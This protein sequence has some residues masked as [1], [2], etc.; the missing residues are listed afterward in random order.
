MPG[1]CPK[2]RFLLLG[3]CFC[4]L[5]SPVK[6]KNIALFCSSLPAESSSVWKAAGIGVAHS[7]DPFNIPDFTLSE[8][9]DLIRSAGG[10]HY[11]P[12]IPLNEAVPGISPENMTRLKKAAS[13]PAILDA[14]IDELSRQGKWS[15]LDGLVD[16]FT[17][18]GIKL[19]LVAGCGY[20]KEAPLYR[21]ADGSMESISPDRL[22]RD[23]YLAAVKW[24]AGAAVRRYGGRVEFW[25]V[26][27][28]INIASFVARFGWRIK[29]DSWADKAYCKRLISALAAI[30]HSEGVKLKKNLKTT[31]NFATTT[32]LYT[33]NIPMDLAAFSAPGDLDI[34]GLDFYGNYLLGWP[35]SADASVRQLKETVRAAGGKPVWILE[36]GYPGGPSQRGFSEKHQTEYF[37]GFINGAYDAGADL[38]LVFGW[39]WNPGGWFTDS[40]APLPWWKPMAVERYWSPIHIG[41]RPDGTKELV[42]AGAWEEFKKAARKIS[43]R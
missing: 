20:Q 11:R 24:L 14:M 29:E 12:H 8:I 1:I 2:A 27:N 31:H 25:Q 43:G 21:K 13:E 18:K 7:G 28:E 34:I 38:V 39:F 6:I 10:T 19:I 35:D 30:V 15:R 42:F 9:A 16:A 40:K 17:R 5:L 32:P 26:E 22:G 3:S 41:H 23:L 4:K 37:K 33:R 36:T